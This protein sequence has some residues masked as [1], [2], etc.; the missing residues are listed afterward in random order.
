MLTIGRLVVYAILCL[1]IA[2][3][4]G[5]TFLARR[6][7]NY[8]IVFYT[9]GA[10]V[11]LFVLNWLFG[12]L[13]PFYRRIVQPHVT[14]FEKVMRKII[15]TLLLIGL[16]C[17]TPIFTLIALGILPEFFL[18]LFV[19]LPIIIAL[20]KMFKDKL[21]AAFRLDIFGF[22]LILI[23]TSFLVI[24]LTRFG[25]TDKTCKKVASNP[26][27]I[28]IV[29]R[30]DIAKSPN[31]ENCF[32]YDIKSDPDADLLFFTLKERRSGF[33]KT[34]GR[35]KIPQD[36]ICVTSLSSPRFESSKMI[37]I[38]GESTATYP[39]R[40]TVNPQR[41]EIYVV[42]LDINGNHSVKVVSYD[43]EWRI[44]KSWK[45]DYE[46]IRVYPS[47][48]GDELIVL[49]YEDC[50]G[51]Y[52]I[53]TFERHFFKGCESMKNFIVLRDTLFYNP[54]LK[55]Y[56]A[57]AIFRKFEVLDEKTFKPIIKSD[58]IVPTIGLDYHEKLN[59]VY[60]AA[61]LT[62]EIIVLNG[63]TLDTLD[64]IWTGIT[65]RELYIDRKRDA[66]VTAG[67]AD[68]YLDF[69]DVHTHQRLARIFVGK[70]ARGIHIEQ[71]S[72]RIFV[73]SSCGLFEV[74][75]EKLL[76]RHSQPF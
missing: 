14:K 24:G 12:L 9:F 64:R 61:T 21:P 66:V 63:I 41:K 25:S 60:T 38:V 47:E 44:K 2:Y 4:L 42:V 30:E 10:V 54:S 72:G 57:S 32:P 67:Y 18:A 35:L 46:P 1:P 40:I 58:V 17:I 75:T 7:Q 39:Q 36:A 74:K 52:D 51:V 45:L 8:K 16:I 22:L 59:R 26:Y 34:L 68:G 23:Y 13:F 6:T 76:F 49:G 28:P 43:N 62:R 37:P 27:L 73:A 29:T 5:I 69:Y 3:A 15:T 20:S 65:V 55:G 56:Y 53:E 48:K 31:I 33:I 50:I 19:V 11:A 70:L 71:K